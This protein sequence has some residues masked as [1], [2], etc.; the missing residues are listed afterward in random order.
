MTLIVSYALTRF[1]VV[2]YVMSL[3][4]NVLSADWNTL[5]YLILSAR[6]VQRQFLGALF[7]LLTILAVTFAG[8]RCYEYQKMNAMSVLYAFATVAL[9][10][11]RLTNALLVIMDMSNPTRRA[12]SY[13]GTRYPTVVSAHRLIDDV[14]FVIKVFKLICWVFAPRLMLTS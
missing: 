8:N 13:A 5:K 12:A 11:P 9:A 4:G 2:Q 6:L 7:V 1:L 10:R 14:L 3:L